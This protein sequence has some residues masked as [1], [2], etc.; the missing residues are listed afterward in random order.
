MVRSSSSL[1]SFWK[2]LS[3]RPSAVAFLLVDCPP[4]KLSKRNLL[5]LFLKNGRGSSF[6]FSFHFD[7]T[8]AAPTNASFSNSFLCGDSITVQA[9]MPTTWQSQQMSFHTVICAHE[10]AVAKTAFP[11]NIASSLRLAAWPC[12]SC[13]I[14]P[15]WVFGVLSLFSLNI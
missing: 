13:H 9:E 5:L 14:F 12:L 7:A 11:C 4:L 15:Q 6:L 3:I 8:V 2:I 1:F 10:M